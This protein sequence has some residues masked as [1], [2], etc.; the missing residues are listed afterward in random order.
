M[1]LAIPSGQKRPHEK[2]A[3]TFNLDEMFA[4]TIAHAPSFKQNE[5]TELSMASTSGE[6]SA[7]EALEKVK[8]P[9][10]SESQV[11]ILLTLPVFILF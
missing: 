10:N 9:T 5:T 8:L 11:R 6:E 4:Q 7:R 2:K 1:I 3:R